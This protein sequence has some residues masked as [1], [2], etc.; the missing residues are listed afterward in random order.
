MNIPHYFED[1]H[2]LHVGTEENRS[3]YIPFSTEEEALMDRYEM[4]DRYL[5][6]SGLWGFRYFDSVYDLPD[7]FWEDDISNDEIPVPS[8]WQNHGY[9]HH[10]YTNV[11]YPFPYD[12]PYVPAENPV[13][14]YQRTFEVGRMGTDHYY[15]N[16]EGVDSCFY[17]WVNGEFAGYSQVSHSTSEFDITDKI[18]EGDND[19]TVAVLKWCDGSYLEDQDKLRMSGIFRDVYLLIRPKNHIRDFFCHVDL[20]NGYQDGTLD[21]EMDLTGKTAV[22]ARL[23]SPE[24]ETLDEK[25]VRGGKVSFRVEK[26]QKWNAENPVQYT[27]LLSEPEEV[28][29]QKIGFRKIEVKD[30]VICLN[31]QNIKFR[32]VNRHDSDPFTGY[33]ISEEQALTDLILMKQH[34]INAIRTSHYPNAPWFPKMCSKYGF[35]M[36]GEADLETHGTTSIEGEA[37]WQDKYCLIPMN[38]DFEE[39]ILDREQRNVIRDK[40]NA[41]IVIWSLG[42][43][44]G[45]GTGLEKAGRWVKAYDPSR[46]LHYERAMESPS[47]R[48]NDISMLDVFS[49]MYPPLEEI[50][51]YFADR[52]KGSST[53]SA[54]RDAAAKRKMPYI[55]CEYIHSMGNGPGDAEDYQA[56]IQKYDGLAGGFVW[57]WCDHS[58]YAGVTKDGRPK[59]LYGGDFGEFPDD[60]NFCVD[61]MV[62]PD[63]TPSES[64]LEY[65]NVIRPVRAKVTNLRQHKIAFTNYYDFTNL[66]EAVS[67][68]YEITVDGVT[69]E[70]HPLPELDVE[71]HQT[72][73]RELAFTMPRKGIVALNLFYVRREDGSLV[74]AGDELGYEQLILRGAGEEGFPVGEALINGCHDEELADKAA[75]NQTKG[76]RFTIRTAGRELIV[77]N[78]R[79]CYR[80]DTLTGSFT[81]LCVDN[82]ERLEAPMSFNLFRAPTDN[83]RNIVEY[84]KQ[85]GFDRAIP[86][87]YSAKA[88][89]V[90]GRCVLHV[91]M[92]Y[93]PVYLQKIVDLDVTYRI[94]ADGT[95]DVDVKAK[96]CMDMAELP[97]FGLRLMMPKRMNQA[98]YLG[99]GP[100]ESYVDKRLASYFGLFETTAQENGEDYIKPQE[101]GSHVGCLMASVTDENGEG[102]R[103]TAEKPFSFNISCYTQEELAQKKHN[104][105]LEEAPYTVVCLDYRMAGIGSNSCGPRLIEKYR[106]NEPS[107]EFNIRLEMTGSGAKKGKA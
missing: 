89:N 26:V 106:F 32:G 71:P 60:G 1:P 107:F 79:L 72:V 16:F 98:R 30:G 95:I 31:G 91:K 12:P 25:P 29:S 102:I 33:T 17:V 77:S 48:T 104:F 90:D 28:L 81:S 70:S 82:T 4:S 105:E 50:E 54:V 27:L 21:I 74:S 65:K 15:L 64:L 99:Y 7:N 38:P 51:S 85:C 84:W 80:F 5:S 46:L 76:S 62:F 41:A 100:Y 44:S 19:L 53:E 57:E 35:Y 75:G 78:D 67:G 14:V 93:A 24:G 13:G 92:S 66:K 55:M 6:L 94:Y 42:N 101:N 88:R 39:A 73:E 56:L 2:T 45:Y 8:V 97:R 40:N 37:P 49:R 96:K 36:I 23:L 43:E 3:Y 18:S 69:R 34:N 63:R 68:Y 47:F 58:V 52:E 9:D 87:V 103:V 11:R 86:R 59:Y 20:V 61:G 10:Q 83:D 22:S